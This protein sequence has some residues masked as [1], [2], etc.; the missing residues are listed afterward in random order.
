MI[1]RASEVKVL[2]SYYIE[3]LKQNTFIAYV[4]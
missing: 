4:K 3:K 1:V 2:L